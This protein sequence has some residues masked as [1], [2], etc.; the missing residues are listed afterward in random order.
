MSLGLVAGVM[1]LVSVAQAAPI[2]VSVYDGGA[3]GS[4]GAP[5]TTAD[6]QPF[7]FGGLVN[8]GDVITLSTTGSMCLSFG[9]GCAGRD[10]A[11]INAPPHLSVLGNIFGAL[12]YAI[13]PTAT[14]NTSGF[15]AYDSNDVAVGI[16]A[17]LV[18]FAG[19]LITFTA[20][21]SGSIFFGVSDSAFWDNSGPGFDVTMTIAP[22]AN[23]PAPGALALLGLGLFG[24]GGLRRNRKAA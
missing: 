15:Q 1:S 6:T 21:Q 14:V 8:A 16:S 23:V 4:V 20:T 11:T 22:E 12:V 9:N 18:Q 3:F 7:V 10:G 17:S 24:I 5:N 13:V 2:H 19:S